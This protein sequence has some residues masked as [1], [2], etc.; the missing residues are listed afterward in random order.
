MLVDPISQPICFEAVVCLALELVFQPWKYWSPVLKCQQLTVLTPHYSFTCDVSIGNSLTE[1]VQATKRRERME[2]ADE[3]FRKDVIVVSK[4]KVDIAKI[5]G[6]PNFKK[7]QK[8]QG[9][10]FKRK[11]AAKTGL[12]V[13]YT[14]SEDKTTTD[15]LRLSGSVL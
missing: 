14:V 9:R 12:F 1:E 5:V 7:T 4:T 3:T 6:Q 11:S 13:A 10:H 2:A 15:L 8:E